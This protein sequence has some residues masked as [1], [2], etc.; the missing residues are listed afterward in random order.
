MTFASGLICI[1]VHC[2]GMLLLLLVALYFPDKTQSF[3]GFRAF[4]VLP[5][6]PLLLCILLLFF[7]FLWFLLHLFPSPP[8]FISD[9]FLYASYLFSLFVS[10]VNFAFVSRSSVCR[11]LSIE[12]GE[13]GCS[14]QNN[15]LSAFIISGISGAGQSAERDRRK[16]GEGQTRPGLLCA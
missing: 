4:A 11:I 10:F 14:K 1:L 2:A 15:L 16:H 5:L 6:P 13:F 7:P 8:F 12:D 9:P 3:K